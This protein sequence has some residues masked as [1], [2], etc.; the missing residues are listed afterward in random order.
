M[1]NL[2]EVLKSRIV[3]FDVTPFVERL[4]EKNFEDNYGILVQRVTVSG[5]RVPLFDIFD[6]ESSNKPMLMIYINHKTSK[7]KI[8]NLID[9]HGIIIF[10]DAYVRLIFI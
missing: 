1:L 10:L 3:S 8:I 4:T 5:K 6:F 9:T 2:T 7:K